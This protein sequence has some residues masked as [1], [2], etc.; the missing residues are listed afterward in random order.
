MPFCDVIDLTYV[1]DHVTDAAAVHFPA[2]DEGA[3]EP[4]PLIA[5]EDE[6]ALSRRVF[7]RRG[8]RRE[9]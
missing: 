4:G 6:P 1:P 5:H 7:T 8:P 2:I 3:W 9:R